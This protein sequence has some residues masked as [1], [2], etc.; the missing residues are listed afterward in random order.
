MKNIKSI[1]DHKKALKELHNENEFNNGL[2]N[3]LTE[4]LNNIQHGLLHRLVEKQ[5]KNLKGMPKEQLD[6]AFENAVVKVGS[7][8]KSIA[9]NGTPKPKNS[10]K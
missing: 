4:S 10:K 6:N 2:L 9:Q 3:Y 8:L 7:E 5:K 1:A